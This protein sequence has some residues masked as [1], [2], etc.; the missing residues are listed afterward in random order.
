MMFAVDVFTTYATSVHILWFAI[1]RFV[2]L[3]RPHQF[4]SFAEKYGKVKFSLN[5]FYFVVMLRKEEKR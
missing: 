5:Y 4:K 2:S 3:H 1:L